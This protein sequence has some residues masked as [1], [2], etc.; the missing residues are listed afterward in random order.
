[1]QEKDPYPIEEPEMVFVEGGVFMF[2]CT[3]EEYYEVDEFNRGY[4]Y[5]PQMQKTVNSF[6]ISKYPVTQKLW[7]EVMRELPQG[8]Y[9]GEG[10]DYP[11]YYDSSF[12]FCIIGD[13][14]IHKPYNIMET[15]LF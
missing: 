3:E 9:N 4:L 12:F 13:F 10:E 6:Y 2:G 5:Y 7:E 11:I 1:V 14:H 15:K 8:M